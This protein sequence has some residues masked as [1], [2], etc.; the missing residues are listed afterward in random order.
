VGD[1]GSAYEYE[2]HFDALEIYCKLPPGV[3]AK[4]VRVDTTAR[5][6]SIGLK[7]RPPYL[8]GTFPG[9]IHPEETVWTIHEAGEIKIELTKANT[10]DHWNGCIQLDE[11]WSCVW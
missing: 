11:S 1:V 3:G 5:S 6:I 7:G 8:K 4:Q 10:T 2:L 9:V